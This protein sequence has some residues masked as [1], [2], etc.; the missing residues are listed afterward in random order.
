MT[1]LGVTFPK[2]DESVKHA[3]QQM[4]MAI[5]LGRKTACLPGGGLKEAHRVESA[6]GPRQEKPAA[7][8]LDSWGHEELWVEVGHEL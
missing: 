3:V 8:P 1:T 7:G 4:N 2:A 6:R 5:E